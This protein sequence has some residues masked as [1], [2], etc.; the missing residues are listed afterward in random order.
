MRQE[1]VLSPY[2][3]LAL[4]LPLC[5]DPLPVLS[6]TIAGT[7]F[8]VTL[9]TQA[10]HPF[11]A[12]VVES[13]VHK[14]WATGRF[15]DIQVESK[16]EPGG[17]ALVFRAHET[18]QLRLRE[19]HIEPNSFGLHPKIA[20]GTLMNPLRAHEIATEAQKRLN[21]EGYLHAKVATA[22]VRVSLDQVDLRLTVHAG[23]PVDLKSVEFQGD[24]GLRPRELRS[25][26]RAARIRRVLP[27]IPGIWAGWRL[28]PAYYGPA[29]DADLVRLRSLYLSRG[30]LDANVR[31]GDVEINGK[32]AK[33]NILVQSG[34]RYANSGTA[35]LCSCLMAARRDAERKGV[36]DFSATVDATLTAHVA[37]GPPYHVGRIEFTGHH[38]F[39][40][41]AV[42]RNM[43][44]D[45][46]APLDR[47]LLRK[48]IAR[49]NR[50]GWFNPIGESAIAMHTDAATG[51]A[52]VTLGLT[53][54]QHRAWSI[55]GPVGPLSI[56]GPLQA[57]LS[58]RLPAW[59]SGLLEL[60]TYTASFSLVAFAHPLLPF[61]SIASKSPVLPILS[62]QRPFTPGEGWMSGFII[63]PQLGWQ[64]TALGYATTQIEQ[65]L[66]PRLT[67]DG[68]LEE[69]LQATV[70]RPQGDMIL[71]C[72]PPKPR[73]GNL[74]RGTALALRLLGPS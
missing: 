21:A 69:E 11:N 61:L 74:R 5:A 43:L 13:D 28:F 56:A 22:I 66:L 38:G 55:S 54:R 4:V 48:S 63:A 8:P 71:V 23:Q 72:D 41:S 1:L 36:L 27:P 10:G 52:D 32:A 31:L 3:C 53:E 64:R 15:D 24:P 25:A 67:G 33:L 44:L 65:R 2:I 51:L 9:A 29:L 62:I 59:G 39:S 18:P 26:L 57:S 46:G 30:Y 20:A 73:L 35:N 17:T 68:A 47:M 19:I 60:S 42:R 7:R 50:T 40:D 70:Q 12:R 45:E 6:V 49:I 16:D 14:L 34:P 58:S 37:E